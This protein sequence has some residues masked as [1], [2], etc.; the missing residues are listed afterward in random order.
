MRGS[1]KKSQDIATSVFC[2]FLG[3]M[4]IYLTY[5]TFPQEGQAVGGLFASSRF[6]PQLVGGIMIL[7]SIIMLVS[8]VFKKP[9]RKSTG[10]ADDQTKNPQA[11]QA[12]LKPIWRL[13]LFILILALYTAL[14]ETI[15]YFLLTPF[16]LLALFKLLNIKKWT[17]AIALALITSFTIGIFFTWLLQVVLPEGLFTL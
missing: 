16:M 9:V 1:D 4:I 13:F 15:G 10:N 5:T 17:S 14:L 8:T 2:V 12:G 6:Y 7:L 3:A 11:A